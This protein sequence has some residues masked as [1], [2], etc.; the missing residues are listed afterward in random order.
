[1]QCVLTTFVLVLPHY[2]EHNTTGMTTDNIAQQNI[3]RQASLQDENQN[4]SY[5]SLSG[6]HDMGQL[7]ASSHPQQGEKGHET[8]KVSAVEVSHSKL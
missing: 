1:M 3:S 6:L 8:G 2:H 4:G 5:G 7:E